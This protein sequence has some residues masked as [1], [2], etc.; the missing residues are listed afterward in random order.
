MQDWIKQT[1]LFWNLMKGKCYL[2][3]EAFHMSKPR[4]MHVLSMTYLTRSVGT[5]SMKFLKMKL[6]KISKNCLNLLK[7]GYLN[8]NPQSLRNKPAENRNRL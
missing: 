3:Q 7:V 8:H 4:Y 2:A 6:R 1:D 5:K